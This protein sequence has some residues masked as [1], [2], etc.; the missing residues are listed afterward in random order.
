MRI[1]KDNVSGRVRV[2][3]GAIKEVAGKLVGNKMMQLKGMV[4]KN[5]GKAQVKLGDLKEQLK[6]GR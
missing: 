3:R 4:Q 1:N 5:V 6:Q 2:A